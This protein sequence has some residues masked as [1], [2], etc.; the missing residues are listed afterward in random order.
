M[1]SLGARVW[2]KVGQMYSRKRLGTPSPARANFSSRRDL[3]V[4]LEMHAESDFDGVFCTRVRRRS[5]SPPCGLSNLC[6]HQ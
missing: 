2:E 6:G 5:V 1:A 4:F 3:E